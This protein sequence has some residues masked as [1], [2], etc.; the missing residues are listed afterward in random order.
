M[1]KSNI[2]EINVHDAKTHLSQYLQAVEAAGTT[3]VICRNHHPIAQL[4][5]LPTTLNPKFTRF[6][7]AAGKVKISSDFNDELTDKELPGFGLKAK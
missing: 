6:G 4:S 3:F 5:V 2:I 7:L 1:T